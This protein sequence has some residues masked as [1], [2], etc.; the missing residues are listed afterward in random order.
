MHVTWIV[1][2]R[3]LS[4]LWI[5]NDFYNKGQSHFITYRTVRQQ[6]MLNTESIHAN[7]GIATKQPLWI[8][9][10]FYNKGQSHF[11]T[12][13][14]IRQQT[15]L[16]TESI[17]ANDGIKATNKHMATEWSRAKEWF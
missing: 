5:I 7:D 9:N 11:I 15:M 3:L 13:R 16:N 2:F 14:T 6:T 10:D 17:H 8:I 1:R 4:P 12:Y